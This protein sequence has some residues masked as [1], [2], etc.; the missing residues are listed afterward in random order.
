MY[1]IDF[2][3]C[4]ASKTIAVTL[5]SGKLKNATRRPHA[6]D[7]LAIAVVECCYDVRTVPSPFYCC[8]AILRPRYIDPSMI[9]SSNGGNSREY[10]RCK[11]K[12]KEWLIGFHGETALTRSTFMRQELTVSARRF[13]IDPSRVMI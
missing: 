11:V 12:R 10:T 13:N 4:G 8:E 6:Y 3:P 9:V 7:G 2:F 1:C 5:N